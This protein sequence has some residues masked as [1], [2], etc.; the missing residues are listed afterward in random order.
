MMP[1]ANE[2]PPFFCEKGTFDTDFLF[3]GHVLFSHVIVSR[4]DWTLRG[5]SCFYCETSAMLIKPGDRKSVV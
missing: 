2:P 4:G 3:K 1:K 5:K